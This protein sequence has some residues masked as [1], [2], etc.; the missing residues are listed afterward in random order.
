MA[1]TTEFGT[2]LPDGLTC[3]DCQHIRRCMAMFGHEP[4]D[5]YCDWAPS[6]FRLR[7][8][9]AQEPTR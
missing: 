9:A 3:G 4:T 2:T 5:T 1:E 8:D 7:D 6:R